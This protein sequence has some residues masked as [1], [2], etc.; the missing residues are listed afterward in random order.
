MG[1]WKVAAYAI[2]EKMAREADRRQAEYDQ[3]FGYSGPGIVGNFFA[4]IRA[5][6]WGRVYQDEHRQIQAMMDPHRFRRPTPLLRCGCGDRNC[7]YNQPGW[8]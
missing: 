6:R 2:D 4:G 1:F 8:R 3:E 5:A 7:R